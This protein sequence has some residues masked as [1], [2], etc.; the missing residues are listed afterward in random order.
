MLANSHIE[1]VEQVSA[2]TLEML[3]V[4]RVSKGTKRATPGRVG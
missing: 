1:E 2:S 4:K 3:K